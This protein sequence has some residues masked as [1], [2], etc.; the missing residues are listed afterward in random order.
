MVLRTHRPLPTYH[1]VSHVVSIAWLYNC[2]SGEKNRCRTLVRGTVAAFFD[3]MKGQQEWMG[4]V[5]S[6]H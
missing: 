3:E 4:L 2:L 5:C 1:K 6:G